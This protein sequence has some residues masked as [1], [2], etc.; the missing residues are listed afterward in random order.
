[1]SKNK[2]GPHVYP[3]RKQ[4][5][6]P[7]CGAASPMVRRVRFAELGHDEFECD[8]CGL[9]LFISRGQTPASVYKMAKDGK[10]ICK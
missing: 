2:R 4:E 1:M 5:K 7:K 3:V 6:C 9:H 10:N 8:K